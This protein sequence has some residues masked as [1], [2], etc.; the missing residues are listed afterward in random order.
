[1]KIWQLSEFQARFVYPNF[2][3]DHQLAT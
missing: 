3:T 1:M 2:D